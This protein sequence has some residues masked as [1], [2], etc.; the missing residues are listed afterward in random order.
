MA[1]DCGCSNSEPIAIVRDDQTPVTRKDNVFVL[2]PVEPTC[3][4]PVADPAN[5]ITVNW[6]AA[7]ECWLLN[8]NAQDNGCGML[9]GPDESVLFDGSCPEVN[10]NGAGG[11]STVGT[12][13]GGLQVTKIGVNQFTVSLCIDENNPPP[14]QIGA[15]GKIRAI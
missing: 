8:W 12:V 9:L 13:S 11:G 2:D 14:F 3:V 6:D 4:A 7:S 1:R 5:P 10:V 15:D